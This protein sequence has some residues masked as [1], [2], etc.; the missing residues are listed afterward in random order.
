MN[1]NTDLV[2]GIDVGTTSMKAHAFSLDGTII[3]RAQQPTLW[4]VGHNGQ[5][6]IDIDL[7]ADTAMQVMADSVPESH[8]HGSVI[9][10]GIT[11]MAET[12]VLI[13][14]RQ[15]PVMPAMAWYDERGKDELALLPAGFSQEFSAA[16]GLAF[17]A[18]CSF[19]KLLWRSHQGGDVPAGARWLNA[20][21]YI[22]FRMTGITITEP[23]LASR[24]GLFDQ[25]TST[26]WLPALSIIGAHDSLIPD[27]LN[28]GTSIG[29]V[30]ES[31]PR[32]LRGAAVTVAGHDH[33]VG[34]VGAGAFGAD[35]L[36]DSCGT[37][38]VILR[39]VSRVLT[40]EERTTLVSRGLSAGRH[41]VP[42]ATAIL[43][44]TRSGLVLGRVLTMLGA[45]DRET[46]REIADAWSGPGT[47]SS[48]V[49]VTEPPAWTNE[50]TISLRGDVTSA[51][52]WAAAMEY[53]LGATS[54]LVHAVDDI[55][56]EYHAAVAAGGWAR[57]DGVFRGKASV[58]PGLQRFNG[59]EPGARGAAA[60]ACLAARVPS[61][62]LAANLA[63][64]FV[65]PSHKEL[66]S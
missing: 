25:A 16:T 28:A 1:A 60:L 55:A 29:N 48:E 36:Y 39:S 37:A 56:G 45:N 30:L 6:E 9:G 19:A 2:I 58:M 13:D 22:A 32:M 38:D 4:Q 5:A 64:S 21:E 27:V 61:V 65:S 35:D 15:R 54:G 49:S 42:N 50:V 40:N 7:L 34:A 8:S 41:C 31:A 47:H 62:P 43:G 20:L 10:I 12:G 52:V 14:A 11:G 3:G 33:L 44:A 17:K 57:L 59:E 46:R 24:T 18:E 66:V 63:A 53:V 51:Q 26:P 23:S